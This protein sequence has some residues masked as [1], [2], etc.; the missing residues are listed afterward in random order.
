M[1]QSADAADCAD[2]QIVDRPA[3]HGVTR[4]PGAP[5]QDPPEQHLWT[6]FQVD[7]QRISALDTIAMT[8]RGWT[9]TLVAAIAGF[10]LSQDHRNFLLAAMLGAVLFGW[11][12]VMYRHTQLLHADRV[13]KVEREIAQ[14][15]RLRPNKPG[16]DKPGEDKPGEDK[17]GEDKPGEDKPGEQSLWLTL[18]RYRSSISFYA[19]M[20]VILL[21]L[22]A[23]LR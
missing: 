20:L 10:S 8:I 1:N 21:T 15:Y 13:N 17:P 2:S 14:N 3:Q 11:L 7:Q 19:V 22:W 6:L 16:E 23:L 9:V 5:T 18:T 12:D 4:P